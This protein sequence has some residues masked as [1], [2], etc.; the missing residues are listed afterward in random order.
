MK[1]PMSASTQPP[2]KPAMMPSTAPIDD[3]DHVAE[4]A[5]ASEKVMPYQIRASTSRPVP[6]LDPERVATS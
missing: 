5:I 4:S 1:R 3:G 2:V 6:R